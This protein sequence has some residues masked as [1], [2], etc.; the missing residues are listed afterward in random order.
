MLRLR[1]ADRLKYFVERQFVKGAHYQL[2]FVVA[3][4]GLISLLG[5]LGSCFWLHSLWGHLHLPA[6]EENIFFGTVLAS[7]VSLRAI[8]RHRFPPTARQVF[9]PTLRH[10]FSPKVRQPFSAKLRHPRMHQLRY[11]SG[12]HITGRSH[13]R[14]EVTPNG[15]PRITLTF[16]GAIQ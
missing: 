4:I 12:T 1:F 5:G 7:L 14:E 11:P 16:S 2:L 3:L 13:D 9:T 15:H 8:M 6:R 10:E